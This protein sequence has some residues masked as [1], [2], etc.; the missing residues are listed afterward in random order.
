MHR[1]GE[2]Q[3]LDCNALLLQAKVQYDQEN[4]DKVLKLY[5]Q[6][7]DAAFSTRPVDRSVDVHTLLLDDP[8]SRMAPEMA[9]GA[10]LSAQSDIGQAACHNQLKQSGRAINIFLSAYQL[11][12]EDRYCALHDDGL[13][14][15]YAESQGAGPG[16]AW[17][18]FKGFVRKAGAM[19]T[20]NITPLAADL[21]VPGNKLPRWWTAAHTAQQM[22]CAKD[23]Q[24]LR[25]ART[26]STTRSK[27][28][29]PRV[30]RALAN[31]GEGRIDF[32]D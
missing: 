18:H 9:K 22:E 29:R 25:R 30:L 7:D 6:A 11:R 10:S 17:K 15:M 23:C 4:Y 12:V 28:T 3:G 21:A 13:V 16:T 32:S 31:V 26:S 19:W 5:E 1:H 27:H 20:G 24:D 8:R 14:G 2:Q